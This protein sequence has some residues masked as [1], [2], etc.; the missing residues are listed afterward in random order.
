MKQ[1]VSKQQIK[2]CLCILIG[3]LFR[4]TFTHL[5]KMAIFTQ[6]I[7][8]GSVATHLM[9]GGIFSGHFT[10]NLLPS[11]PVKEFLKSVKIWWSYCYEF[12]VFFFGTWYT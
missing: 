3:G 4:F 10:R 1:W 7:S 5:L 2:N 9:C 12:G 11:L 6:N 8:Q